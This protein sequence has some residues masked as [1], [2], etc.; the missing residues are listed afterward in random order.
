MVSVLYDSLDKMPPK[1]KKVAAFPQAK[2]G[3]ASK[4]PAKVFPSHHF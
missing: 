4:K 3:A 1:G 2:S